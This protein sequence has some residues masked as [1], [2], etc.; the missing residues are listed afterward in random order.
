MAT[1]TQR[2]RLADEPGSL[3]L[4]SKETGLSLAGVPLLRKTAVGFA[5]R[6]VDELGAL[7]KGAYGPDIDATSMSSGLAVVAEALNRG[8]LGRAMIAALH[9]RLSEVTLDGAVLIAAANANLV[10]F[11]PLE[12]RNWRGWWTTGSAAQGSGTPPKSARRA[13]VAVPAVP[14]LPALEGIG[15]L[16]STV[17]TPIVLG[18]AA[19]SLSG[20]TPQQ[21]KKS[22]QTKVDQDDECDELLRNDM[23]NC[24]IVKAMRGAQKAAICRGVANSRYSECLVGGTAGVKTPP[25]WGN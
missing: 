21:P 19:M 7:M 11:N 9:L 2:Y 17:A 14:A 6:P 20:D 4:S 13:G 8:D 16:L 1:D 23:I 22:K 25:Y 12:P 3:G 15:S 10:K 5:P 24:Q 18:L